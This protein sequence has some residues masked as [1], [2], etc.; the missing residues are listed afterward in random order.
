MDV[1]F[2]HPEGVFSLRV[3]GVL[4]HNG[5]V[6]LQRLP[7][8]E[9]YAF[10]GGHVQLGETCEN[11]LI[12][13]FREELHVDVRPEKLLATG[14]IFIPWGDKPCHQLGLYYLL[15]LESPRTLPLSGSIASLDNLEGQALPLTFE[16]VPLAQLSACAV[17]PPQAAAWVLNPSLPTG[18]FVYSELSP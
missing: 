6:L 11:A 14:E 9:G 5:H 17:Y 7:R 16:W 4:L 13:E 3:A 12:R 15:Q 10:I 8:S 18:H 2:H 1:L